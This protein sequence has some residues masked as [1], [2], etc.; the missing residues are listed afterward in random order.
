M[1]A[2][3]AACL[4]VDGCRRGHPH[5][6]AGR[7]LHG[8]SGR[9]KYLHK[10][11]AITKVKIYSV[12]QARSTYGELMDTLTSWKSVTLQVANKIY[13]KDGLVIGSDFATDAR[14]VFKAEAEAIDFTD[15]QTASDTINEWVTS[16]SQKNKIR[17]LEKL[18]FRL[19]ITPT[20]PLKTW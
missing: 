19:R 12:H 4:A 3:P 11:L 14:D 20:I 9:C 2:L 10:L 13:V 6:A 1:F 15:S 17:I 7:D 18:F 8:R 16:L 5:R